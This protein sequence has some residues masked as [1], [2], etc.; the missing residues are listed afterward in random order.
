MK[1]QQQT[2]PTKGKWS[3]EQTTWEDLVAL[4]RVSEGEDGKFSLSRYARECCCYDAHLGL[5]R[6]VVLSGIRWDILP[7]DVLAQILYSGQDNSTLER[8]LSETKYELCLRMNVARLSYGVAFS[9]EKRRRGDQVVNTVNE[10]HAEE[11]H[12]TECHL[13]C[14]TAFEP[15]ELA[16]L[17]SP[18]S[19]EESTLLD[20]VHWLVFRALYHA[21]DPILANSVTP[22]SAVTHV[23]AKQEPGVPTVN[24]QVVLKP[25]PLL[26]LRRRA[27]T[28]LR[29]QGIVVGGGDN[30]STT[31][32]P[33]SNEMND[34]VLLRFA[35]L[36]D[37]DPDRLLSVL[38]NPGSDSCHVGVLQQALAL[39]LIYHRCWNPAATEKLYTRLS[40]LG[41]LPS[42][43]LGPDVFH[44]DD[45]QPVM[46]SDEFSRLLGEPGR[47]SIT[48]LLVHQGSQPDAASNE[49]PSQKE[50][51]AQEML[52]LVRHWQAKK[53]VDGEPKE[54]TAP[55]TVA[56]LHLRPLFILGRWSDS[57]FSEKLLS[58]RQQGVALQCIA[59]WKRLSPFRG[60]ARVVAKQCINQGLNSSPWR[61][62]A[63]EALIAHQSQ[64]WETEADRMSLQTLFLQAI[65]D[66]L[67]IQNLALL[68]ADEIICHRP[69][70]PLPTDD[71][72]EQHRQLAFFDECV[73]AATNHRRT[74]LLRLLFAFRFPTGISIAALGVKSC[75]IAAMNGDMQAFEQSY[76]WLQSM[77]PDEDIVFVL[78]E[79]V[80]DAAAHF[81]RC[82]FLRHFAMNKAMLLSR[83]AFDR[84]GG[85]GCNGLYVPHHKDVTKDFLQELQTYLLVATNERNHPEDDSAKSDSLSGPPIDTPSASHSV[86]IPSS[87][88]SKIRTLK[89]AILGMLGRSFE[90]KRTYKAKLGWVFSWTAALILNETNKVAP[91]T[92]T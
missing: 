7:Q 41:V 11:E 38:C 39:S 87:P 91:T 77:K 89:R 92:A 8:L 80:L 14:P 37:S 72:T 10:D 44:G 53:L 48:R 36:L 64:P 4:A 88:E 9:I 3:G 1:N 75:I 17:D 59:A 49:G 2:L 70:V 86:E 6:Y 73:V 50:L 66:A 67:N 83:N 85:A 55:L 46:S 30:S 51:R 62:R 68:T 24:R 21:K 29:A 69:L 60:E 63:I 31:V 25:H 79:L 47:H 40:Q 20:E 84:L 22:K 82:D 12:D 78:M 35:V 45:E 27:W 61:T 65:A 52:W 26:R 43:C 81:G 71:E 15:A 74:D 33:D 23:K 54:S 5:D 56:A 90:F 57:R 34:N 19:F 18:P 28:W 76:V 16:E 13:Y 58:L 32:P 42:F